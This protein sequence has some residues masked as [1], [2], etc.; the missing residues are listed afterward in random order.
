MKMSALSAACEL[1]VPTIKYYLREGL[2]EPGVRSATNQAEYGEDH[3]RRLRLIR[4]LTDLGGMSIAGVRSILAAMDDDLTPLHD[5]LGLAHRALAPTAVATDDPVLADAAAEVRTLLDQLGW[6]LKEHS[7]AIGQVARTL[8]TLRSLGWDVDA[9]VFLPYAEAADRIAAWELA[10][11][12]PAAEPARI[13]EGVVVGTI[14]FE[15]AL[16]ALRRLAEE[17]HSFRTFVDPP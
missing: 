6:R 17:H 16:L 3:L 1:P 12:D 14:V 9:R 4:A 7:P 2:V 13:V 15:S 5:V 11:F 10:R 8:V